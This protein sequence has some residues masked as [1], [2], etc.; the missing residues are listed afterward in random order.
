MHCRDIR[1]PKNRTNQKVTTGCLN[2]LNR[3]FAKESFGRSTCWRYSLVPSVLNMDSTH[4]CGRMRTAACTFL[5]AAWR[6]HW[7][8]S[9]GK[10]L[11]KHRPD[12]AAV[13]GYLAQDGE[14]RRF[15]Q[16]RAFHIDF[17]FTFSSSRCLSR[18]LLHSADDRKPYSGNGFRIINEDSLSDSINWT[19]VS[20]A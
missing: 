19:A 7:K 18:E 1:V 20:I 17:S 11:A 3:P 9:N 15:D 16:D 13:F 5:Y 14:H 6:L 8:L 4:I 10:R 12:Q 2:P